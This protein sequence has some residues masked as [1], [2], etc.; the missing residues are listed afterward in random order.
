MKRAGFLMTIESGAYLRFE[1]LL[2]YPPKV[3]V[4]R[5]AHFVQIC[6]QND[7]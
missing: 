7:P 3:D 4:K 6:V 5:W 2:R 1:E